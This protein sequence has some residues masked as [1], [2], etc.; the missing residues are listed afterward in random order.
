MAKTQIIELYRYL[1]G[2]DCYLLYGRGRGTYAFC[3]VEFR[4][5][6]PVISKGLRRDQTRKLKR[7]Q[8]KNGFKLER[9]D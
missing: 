7:T 8:L 9:T 6:N 2:R 3:W 5:I 4:R 1:S